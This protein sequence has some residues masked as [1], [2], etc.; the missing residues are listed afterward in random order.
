MSILIGVIG[1]GTFCISARLFAKYFKPSLEIIDDDSYVSNKS[2]VLRENDYKFNI[3]SYEDM[4]KEMKQWVLDN[5]ELYPNL[6]K[7]MEE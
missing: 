4:V 6:I 3:P 2:L 7:K 5:K 1:V